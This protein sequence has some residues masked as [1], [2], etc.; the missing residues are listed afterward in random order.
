MAGKMRAKMD[1]TN[2]GRRAE[3]GRIT[4]TGRRVDAFDDIQ[5]ALRDFKKGEMVVVI[6]DPSRENEGDLVFPAEKI[7]PQK[8]NFMAKYGRGLICLA[9]DG[10]RLD[11]LKLRPMVENGREVR[12]ASFSVSVDAKHGITTGISAHDRAKTIKTMI[13][14]GTTADDLTKPGHIFPLRYREGGVMVRAGHTEAGVDLCKLAG[15]YPAAVICEI[16]NEDGTM[17]RTP[18]LKRFAKKHRLH[19]ITIADLIEYRRKTEK[20]VRQ[21]LSTELPTEM[22]NF[23]LS[24]YED[25][26]NR[27]HHIALVRGEPAGKKN[28]LVRV[29]SSCLTGDTFHSLRCDCGQQLRKSMELIREKKLGVV[30]YLHQEGR[31]I[32]LINKLHTYKLQDRGLDTVEAN[33][34]LG[35]KPDMRDYGIGAQILSDLGLSTI[36]LLTN[37]P[38]K[39]AGLEGYGLKVTERVPI[40]MRPKT[41]SAERYLTTKKRKLGHLLKLCGR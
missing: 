21:V 4:D 39:I 28:V 2:T 1:K 36:R 16:M 35:F 33:I 19:I 32:G 12:E 37:N 14:S 3:A 27:E 26:I 13:S 40:E 41:R 8:I 24:L 17:A 38:R 31:G 6:D 22:G 10:K 23:K 7:T 5:G 29:H 25:T 15:L 11:K 9:I 34:K 30:L 18:Q 20:L